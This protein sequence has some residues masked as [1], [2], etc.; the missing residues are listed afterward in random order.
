LHSTF[1]FRSISYLA[2][3]RITIIIKKTIKIKKRI[4][5]IPKPALAALL[6]TKIPEKIINAAAIIAKIQKILM[7]S[8]LQI[9]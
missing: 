8:S 3:A 2:I 6:K 7:F 5:S 9:G 1:Y 4:F